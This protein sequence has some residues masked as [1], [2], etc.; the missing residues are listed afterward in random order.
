[1]YNVF[2]NSHLFLCRY[3]GGLA[4]A[5]HFDP[6]WLLKLPYMSHNISN[7]SDAKR[8]LSTLRELSVWLSVAWSVISSILF[9]CI[10][11]IRHDQVVVIIEQKIAKLVQS[12]KNNVVESSVM[13]EECLDKAKWFTNM[14]EDNYR[15]VWTLYVAFI[16]SVFSSAF[17]R[18]QLVH[19]VLYLLYLLAM[20]IYSTYNVCYSYLL[21][22][23]FLLSIFV[24]NRRSFPSN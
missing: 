17:I 9:L 18:F 6:N 24:P 4:C 21:F 12:E 10:A 1:M 7:S 16:F 3:T 8:S 13:L 19:F 14:I 22:C 5:P 23:T 15:S 2:T 11:S 20:C